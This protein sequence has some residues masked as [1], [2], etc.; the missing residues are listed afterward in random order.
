MF[1]YHKKRVTT[2]VVIII[3]LAIIVLAYLFLGAKSCNS[4]SCF[5]EGMKS[6][7]GTNYI[8]EEPEAT[9]KYSVIGIEDGQCRTDV[10]LL[11]IKKGELGAQGLEGYEM[12]CFY[13][14]GVGVYPEKDLS[15]CHG[16]L[17]EELQS[18]IIERLHTQI[19]ENIGQV[20]EGLNSIF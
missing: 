16:R 1:R 18:I 12:S 19:I 9:W 13:P 17:R 5:Q 4:F 2:V 15:K 3:I 7:T 11:Q 10:K 14:K 6:C 20:D 8:N